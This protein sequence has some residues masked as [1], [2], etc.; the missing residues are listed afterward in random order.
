MNRREC[1]RCYNAPEF[2]HGSFFNGDLLCAECL[3]DEKGCPNYGKEE[4]RG[5]GTRADLAHL[6]GEMAKRPDKEKGA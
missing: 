3:K 6:F 2:L 1:D 4:F 5:R